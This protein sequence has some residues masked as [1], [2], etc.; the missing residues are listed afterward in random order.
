MYWQV[1]HERYVQTQVLQHVYEQAAQ[2]Y[3][4]PPQPGAQLVNAGTLQ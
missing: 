4:H 3:L 1:E 2:G